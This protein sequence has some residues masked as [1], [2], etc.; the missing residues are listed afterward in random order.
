[1]R[2]PGGQALRAEGQH[3]LS[4]RGRDGLSMF[5]EQ[6]RREKVHEG[7][8]S[9]ADHAGLCRLRRRLDFVLRAKEDLEGSKQGR[10]ESCFLLRE[11][12]CSLLWI[13]GFQFHRMHFGRGNWAQQT[14]E[15]I[16]VW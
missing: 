15:Q 10:G 3:T 9:Q 4:P 5:K 11:G 12:C 14:S 13:H 6:G 8:E 7:A 1:M 16:I 2:E